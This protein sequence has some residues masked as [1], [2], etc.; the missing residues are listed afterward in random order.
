[1]KNILTITPTTKGLIVT[2]GV[3]SLLF[4]TLFI[5]KANGAPKNNSDGV[6]AC[7]YEGE[8]KVTEGTN[9]GT[10]F[11]GL[12]SVVD[13]G[14]N[15]IG[16]DFFVRNVPGS[17]DDKEKVAVC[18]LPSGDL[19]KAKTMMVKGSAVQK[20]LDKGDFLGACD[21][22]ANH[23]EMSGEVNADQVDMEF[24]LPNR[25]DTMIGTGAFPA[26]AQACIEGTNVEGDLTGPAADDK[27]DWIFSGAGRLIIKLAA[28]YA[29]FAGCSY[30][31][32]GDAECDGLCGTQH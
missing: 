26:E 25:T 24:T 7:V 4:L 8:M 6:N 1:M 9:A 18:H 27:G 11:K 29:C 5:Q 32:G 30:A 28:P 23:I 22:V 15:R 21:D 12:F 2:S 16:G 17:L 20:Y 10:I 19:S 3:L 13:D 31:G 14:A